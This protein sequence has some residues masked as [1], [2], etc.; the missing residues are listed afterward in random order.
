[1]P[2]YRVSLA[3]KIFPASDLS[4]QI[5]TAGTEASGTGCMKFMIN[6]AMTIGTRDGATIEMSQEVGEENIFLFGKRVEEVRALQTKGYNPNDYINR[7]KVLK[8]VI[9]LIS[10]DA[11]S[12][13][14]KGIFK[15]ILDYLTGSDHYFVCADFESYSATQHRIERLYHHQKEWTEKAIVNVAKSGYFSSDRTILEYAKDVWDIPTKQ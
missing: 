12:V 7:C 15:P 1:M 13:E 3:E 14:E 5:S 10:H 6:G 8:K 11:F 4:E 2:N 9:R